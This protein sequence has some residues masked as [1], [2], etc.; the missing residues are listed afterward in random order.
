MH[1]ITYK[2]TSHYLT[3]STQEYTI[4]ARKR[5]VIISINPMKASP[6]TKKILWKISTKIRYFLRV[7]PS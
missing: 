1:R 4:N 3:V 5:S 7:L 2:I 6:T